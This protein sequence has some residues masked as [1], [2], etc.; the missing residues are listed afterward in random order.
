[1]VNLLICLGSPIRLKG[2][3]LGPISEFLYFFEFSTY[4]SIG[5]HTSVDG[6][7]IL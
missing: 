4:L 7:A 5:G 3:K 6:P 1:M 2:L